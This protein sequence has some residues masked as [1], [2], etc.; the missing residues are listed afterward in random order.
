[1]FYVRVGSFGS[2]FRSV[3]SFSEII[4]YS[5]DTLASYIPF[6]L[7]IFLNLRILF[8][9]RKQRQRISAETKSPHDSSNNKE[10]LI[11][12]TEMR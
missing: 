11:R 3:C 1:M 10:E 7:I 12:K 9:S 4:K 2:Q 5:T 6:F 8:S